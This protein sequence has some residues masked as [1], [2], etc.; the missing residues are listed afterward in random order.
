MPP[1]MAHLASLRRPILLLL[2]VLLT[3][4][5]SVG[6]SSFS[7]SSVPFSQSLA[8][9]SDGDLFSLARLAEKRGDLE[10]ADQHYRHL[11]DTEPNHGEA[12][13]RL[14]IVCSRQ[15]RDDEARTHFERAIAI[16]PTSATLHSDLGYHLYT[17]DDFEQAESMLR[18]AIELNPDHAA[19][20]SNLA[21]VLS[22]QRRFDEAQVAFQR[23]A[24]SPAEFHCNMAY[25]FAQSGEYQR[26][27]DQYQFALQSEPENPIAVHGLL[28][29]SKQIPGR[30]P[31]VV[32]RTQG[33]SSHSE[34]VDAPKLNTANVNT[35]NVNTLGLNGQGV[36]E[37]ESAGALQHVESTGFGPLEPYSF[38]ER[39]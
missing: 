30:E 23:T 25:V 27:Q 5:A 28:E 1:I 36:N 13:H 35:A 20:W 34:Q 39:K 7:R 31:V 15:G 21:L 26:A 24:R 9:N 19:A 38:T 11:I 10:K 12:H 14:A 6:C 16:E 37:V 3:G 18:K 2:P 4:G 17:L 22:S 33:A 29:I 8:K 32:A